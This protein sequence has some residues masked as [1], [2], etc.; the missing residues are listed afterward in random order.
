MA[1]VKY[2]VTVDSETGR[3]AKLEK[4]GDAGELT[5]VDMSELSF[6]FGNVGSAGIVVNIYGGGASFA[7]RGE[8]QEVKLCGEDFC[9]CFPCKRPPGRSR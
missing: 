1:S 6:D 8:V 5:P 4:V 3:A 7:P 9:I 2:L